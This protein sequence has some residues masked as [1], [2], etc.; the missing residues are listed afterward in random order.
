[1]AIIFSKRSRSITIQYSHT[2]LHRT[3]EEMAALHAPPPPQY[4]MV[5]NPLK[6]V[7]AE[8]K[9]GKKRDA[10]V[11]DEN[12]QPVAKKHKKSQKAAAQ[13]GDDS[14]V[15]L[16]LLGD[17]EAGPSGTS[18]TTSQPK[19]KQPNSR[20]KKKKKK[21]EAE[22]KD[23]S[24][25]QALDYLQ[26]TAGEKQLRRELAAKL[27]SDAGVDPAT[28]SGAQF[29]I[30]S[31][32]SPDL[33]AESLS[34]FLEYGAERLQIVHPETTDGAATTATAGDAAAAP[35][36]PTKTRQKRPYKRRSKAAVADKAVT[37]SSAAEM[38]DA[39][40]DVTESAS[41]SDPAPAATPQAKI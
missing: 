12:G 40:G 21:K 15:D 11:L 17:G 20:I 1:M 5:N 32:Q 23:G 41:V 14:V 8:A 9:K 35:D 7:T 6:E 34:L 3:I 33:Q 36:P 13:S 2:P 31:N 29:D 30:F 39:T 19:R 24:A 25:T 10:T 26:V 18:S 38:D 16:S 28:L 37:D 27:L 22:D 4:P